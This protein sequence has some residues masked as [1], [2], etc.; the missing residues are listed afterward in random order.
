ML[1]VFDCQPCAITKERKKKTL[2]QFRASDLFNWAH[3]RRP[4]PSGQ[5]TM[6]LIAYV[7]GSHIA[8]SEGL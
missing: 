7:I 8:N 4:K 2:K 3:I 1:I 6:Y 5:L